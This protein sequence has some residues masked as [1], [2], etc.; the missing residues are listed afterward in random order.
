MNRVKKTLE[1]SIA[2]IALL[3]LFASCATK[4]PAPVPEPVPEPAPIKVEPVPAAP[5]I[6]QADLDSLLAEAKE[7]K[8]KAFDLKLYEVL[9]D[10]YKA[11]DAQLAKGK[12]AYDDKNSAAAKEALDAS[13]AAFKSLIDRGLVELAASGKRDAEDMR[14]LALKADSEARTP[15]RIKAGDGSFADAEKLAGDKKLEESLPAY[16][17]ARLYYELAYKRSVAGALKDEIEEKDFAKWDTGNFQTAANKYDAEEGLWASGKSDDRA[18]GV[19]SLDEAILRFNLVLQ[20]GKETVAGNSKESAES[21]KERSDEIKAYVSAKD[22]YDAAIAALRDADSQ[23]TRKEYE[24]AATG[25]DEALAA[26][27]R[28]Y[29]IAAEKRA[30]AEEAMKVAGEAAAESERKAAEADPI[31]NGTAP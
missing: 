26:F 18:Q 19:D 28:A 5:A 7:L 2:L 6:S 14:S 24:G 29:D 11:A 13:V 15:D 17:T 3:T 10:D 8:K 30:K 9:A 27:E 20:K 31:V 25:Y 22:D 16:E 1:F 21:S 4:P 12:Q 23:Y